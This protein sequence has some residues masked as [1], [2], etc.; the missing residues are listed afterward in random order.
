MSALAGQWYFDGKPD[1]ATDCARI[2]AAQSIYGS[3]D[4]AQWDA[5]AVA[6]GRR[7]FRSLPEDIHDAQPLAS[8]PFVLVADL[9]LD[10]RDDLLRDLQIPPDRARTMADSAVL[11]GA[12][13]RWG[14]ATLDR[15]VGDYAFAIWDR[16]QR[17]LTLARDLMGARPIHYHRGAGFF[18]F[19]SMPKGLHAL[20][21]I[22]RAPDEERVA[23]N[24]LL[25]PEDGTK[26]FFKGVE[27]V[28]SGHITIVT[29]QGLSTRRHWNPARRTLRL[30]ND[31]AYEEGLRHHLDQA[32][33]SRLRGAGNTVGAHLSSGFDSST[34]ASSAALQMAQ[35][36]GRVTAFT[37][38]PREGY[39]GPSPR[40]RYGDEGPLAALTAARYPNIDHVLIR[41]AARSPLDGL[42]RSF[43]LY[44]RP[45]LNLCNNTWANAISDA[46]RERKI[47]VML[48]GQMGNM[49]ISYDGLT[50]L[51]HL[52]RTGRWLRWYR[53]ASAL[54]RERQFRW[55]G[56]LAGSFGPYAPLWLWKAANKTFK[57]D[58]VGP[59]QYSA[60][61]PSRFDELGIT[62]L[63]Q[64][65]ATDLHYRPR[66]DGF[67]TRL[68]VLRRVDVGNYYK[69][70]LGGWS[71]DMRD[72][73][74]DRRLIE[75]CLSLPE[76]QFLRDGRHKS[77]ARRAFA[78]R[79]PAEVIEMRA[80]GYQA[81]DW[82]EGLT[83]ARGQLAEEIGRLEDCG[84]AAAALD[85]PRLKQLVEDWPQ[86]GWETDA[87]SQSYRLALLRGISSGHFLRRA[88]GS[89]A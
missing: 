12:W 88:S 31:A 74:A 9:R 18:A 81:V 67:E 29:A 46:A 66:A 55:R 52:I 59:E 63:A 80:K 84:P 6:L 37:S 13:E 85:L 30:A 73:T 20:P 5:G 26:S 1:A 38:V 17:K 3:A 33:R 70:L 45:V 8:G 62:A 19:A 7:L 21:A 49:T 47:G 28:E 72:P 36:G 44:D 51:P 16:Q 57:G 68:W 53:E 32:V 27:R 14:E 22:P 43:F 40:N 79:L 2:L 61:R 10:N 24:L 83:A 58:E 69:G 39:D 48:S 60:I 87:V 71:L 41:G 86:G 35:S 65:R 78:G 54:V 64:E 11:L 89:N 50:L 34:V 75:F 77:L 42:D 82:H 23:E 15:L 56:A 25:L 4:V 76:D